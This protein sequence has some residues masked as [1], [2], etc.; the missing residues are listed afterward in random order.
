MGED[1][2]QKKKVL[3]LVLVLGIVLLTI[4]GTY[5]FF[6][7]TRQGQQE[8]VLTTGRLYFVYDELSE[9][10]TNIINIQNAFPMSDS[11]GKVQGEPGMFEFEVRA[12][13]QGADI[14]Y[15][16][17]LT[18]EET[19]TLPE[20]S[21]RTYLTEDGIDITPTL[22]EE[23]INSYRDLGFSQ[24]PNLEEK[25]GKTLYQGTVEDS[26]IEYSKTYR[27]RM[28]LDENANTT[29]NG[30]WLYGGMSFSVKVNVYA[31]NEELPKPK[32]LY[33]DGTG[34]NKPDL[35]EGMIPVTFNESTKNWEKAD[36]TAEWYNYA[37]WNWANAVTVEETG[38][39]HN[40][41]YYMNASA[42]E[43]IDM[44][45]INTMWVWIPRYEYNYKNMAEIGSDPNNPGAIPI[46][47]LS[48]TSDSST[49][50][51][52]L[53]PA[54]TF[55]TQKLEGFWY[56]KF[57]PSNEEQECVAT[58]N[59]VNQGCDLTS[60][61]PQIKPN[62][63]SWR[64]IRVSTAFQVAQGMNANKTYGFNK[65]SDVHISKNNEWGA[66]AYLSQSTYGKQGNT[67]YTGANKEVYQNKS[68]DYI[69]GSS[70]GTPST[71]T[72]RTEGQYE[73]DDLTLIENGG[74]LAGPGASTTGTIY[75]V[76]DMSGGSWE[77]VMSVMEDEDGK[78]RSGNNAPG[79]TSGFNGKLYDGT[80]LENSRPFPELKYYNTYDNES[81]VE[82]GCDGG[83][84]L[85]EALTETTGW[86][87]D[88]R[89]LW[90]NS[91][92]PWINRSGAS[93]TNA[94]AGLFL[95]GNSYGEARTADS[96][97]FV[98]TP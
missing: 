55:G 22:K 95:I 90:L 44:K 5:A 32:V 94:E 35:V 50:G 43:I 24:L 16:I 8:N 53:H 28:W 80:Y 66:V 65:T 86:Y 71:N 11:E 30:E 27:F 21:V 10:P 3:I 76:Y 54:F 40:R 68:S 36:V 4:G 97:R 58:V 45:D 87:G 92:N 26:S 12:T 14:N 7:Y 78:P 18:K 79:G 81:T 31:S 19:S 96:F 56:G 57:E 49:E 60:L 93:Y 85:G 72:A 59:D 67:N 42:G 84:C 73:Y 61:T 17:Y 13:T 51:Y 98:L 74:G 33:E 52:M 69:T 23:V 62:V 82:T 41:D 83:V 34:T 91:E 25:V 15:E 38:T 77:R 2:N 9:N 88:F 64:G 37:K 47:F 29:R 6:T 20:K 48:G 46:N 1:K 39:T 70:N 75:G 63:E 89:P